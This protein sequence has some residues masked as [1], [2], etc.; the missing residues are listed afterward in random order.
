M[1][2]LMNIYFIPLNEMQANSLFPNL[3]RIVNKLKTKICIKK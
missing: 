3:F 1:N 2:H